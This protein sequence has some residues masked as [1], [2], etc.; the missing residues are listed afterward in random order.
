MRSFSSLLPSRPTSLV[1]LSAELLDHAGA[2]ADALREGVTIIECPIA[3][4]GDVADAIDALVFGDQAGRGWN[5]DDGKVIIFDGHVDDV[6]FNRVLSSGRPVIVVSPANKIPTDAGVHQDRRYVIDGDLSDDIVKRVVEAVT[7]GDVPNAEAR[8][9]SRNIDAATLTATV[10]PTISAEVAVERLRKLAAKA[11]AD[12]ARAL[13][14]LDDIEKEAAAKKAADA[15]PVSDAAKPSIKLSDLSGFGAARA[16]GLQLADDLKSYAA[17]DLAWEDV[18]RGILLVGAPGTGKTFFV[19]ALAAE[20]DVKLISCS[21]SD[22]EG[23]AGSSYIVK[24]IRKKFDE[25][26]NAAPCILFV[27][28]ID[29]IGARGDNDRNESYWTPIINAFLS[30]M[31]GAVPR[32]GVV[33]IGATNIP[34]RVDKAMQ[35]A[36]RLERTVEIPLPDVAEIGAIIRHHLGSPFPLDDGLLG[37]VALACRGMS[38]ATLAM[39]CREAR[40][41]ARRRCMLPTPLDVRQAA[42]EARPK[43]EPERDQALCRHEAAHAVAAAVL[44]DALVSVDADE[45]HTKVVIDP[46]MTR[47]DVER[48]LIVTLAA[49]RA[50]AML[51]GAPHAGARSDLADATELA[52]DAIAR[53]GLTG[54]VYAYREDEVVLDRKVREDVVD[55]LDDCDL[56]AAKFV[57]AHRDA[58][59]RVAEALRVRRYLDADE[60]KA[61]MYAKAENAYTA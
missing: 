28:E 60:V 30:E 22:L 10:R 38:P 11:D 57:D 50:D 27:D 2:D 52:R 44:G 32:D 35:R 15:V 1:A 31:D 3:L 47:A 6:H 40:R 29:S 18:D 24:A 56:K 55:L 41:S 25:A 33:V 46:W 23:A 12:R 49:R 19:R 43:R 53:W 17:N 5:A 21:Y 14:K 4:A 48:R 16:W 13:D 7:G 59:L 36:G 8:G 9:L 54:A 39:L 58:I 20:A 51:G 42:W 37:G 61:A 34:Q 26:R 45:G